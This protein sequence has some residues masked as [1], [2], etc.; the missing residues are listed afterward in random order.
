[1]QKKQNQ[2]TQHYPT[3]NSPFIKVA[4]V[5]TGSSTA[6]VSAGQALVWARTPTA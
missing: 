1:M 6:E 5:H 2:K 3:H 4:G